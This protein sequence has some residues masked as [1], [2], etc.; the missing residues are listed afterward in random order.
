M[1]SV[2]D[3]A[4]APPALTCQQGNPRTA[5]TEGA[6]FTGA[7]GSPKLESLEAWKLGS[8]PS[9]VPPSANAHARS[10]TAAETLVVAR[11]EVRLDSAD[12]IQCD[13]DDDHDRR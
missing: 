7:S 11:D 2:K 5:S 3:G 9:Y 1:T 4:V 13:A 8:F 6:P 10:A 12:R